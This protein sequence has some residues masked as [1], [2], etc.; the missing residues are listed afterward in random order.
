MEIHHD[1]TCQNSLLPIPMSHIIT[2]SI[3]TPSYNQGQYLA[4]TIESV[5]S[6]EGDFHIDYIIMDG[7]STDNSVDIIK[8]YDALLHTGEW[9][10]RCR[11]ISYRWMSEHDEGQADALLKGFR[12]ANGEILA[13]L[14]SDDIYLPGALLAA[15]DQ[16]RSNPE[17]GLL[18]GD[19]HYCDTAG[20]IV[21]RYRTEEFDLGKLAY[22]N[23]IC[24]PSTFFRRDVFEAVGGLDRT[25]Q[26]AMDYDLWIRIGKRFPCRY[27]PRF[28]STYRLHEASKTIRDETLT[29][30]CEEG[31]AVAI[32]HYGWAP[33]TRIFSLCRTTSKSWL[34]HFLSSSK[35]MVMV[36]AVI[37]TIA[38]SIRLNRGFN[39]NDLKLL[40]REN[41]SKLF[42]DRLEIM[43]GKEG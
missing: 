16:F 8:R 33:L 12:M 36:T 3:I 17:T 29:S 28:L 21:G 20:A 39:R 37:C 35:P 25:L 30:N 7:C 10:I 1:T 40:N 18:Y 31:L 22:F 27:L 9:S 23:F 26:F 6:Q 32:R 11:G 4:E 15:A 2:L 14:N 19:A 42:K 13:W 24:Q 38:T 41:F 5:I 34:P 43:T